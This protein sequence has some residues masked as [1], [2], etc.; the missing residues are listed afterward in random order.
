M[1]KFLLVPL[2]A[3]LVA[4]YCLAQNQTLSQKIA[5][6]YAPLDKSQVPT[7][8]LFD[9]S[10]PLALPAEYRGAP[11]FKSASIDV[12]GMLYGEMLGSYVGTGNLHA[13]FGSSVFLAVVVRP[14]QPPRQGTVA[15]QNHIAMR[16]ICS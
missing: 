12:F 13:A 16:N 1:K 11:G 15:Q 9:L 10:I 6:Q 14:R 5:Y 8:Y 4:G 3:V 7:G 2:L